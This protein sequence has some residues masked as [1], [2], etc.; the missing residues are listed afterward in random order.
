MTVSLPWKPFN[1]RSLV[2]NAC[3]SNERELFPATLVSHPIRLNNRSHHFHCALFPS[4]TAIVTG[5]TSVSQA[6][7]VLTCVLHDL[8]QLYPQTFP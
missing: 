1:L 8:L 3:I 6:Q 2:S 5:V 7:N 4:G